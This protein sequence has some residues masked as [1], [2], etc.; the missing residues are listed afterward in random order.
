MAADTTILS[1]DVGVWWLSNNRAKMLTWEGTTGTYTMNELYSAMQTLQDESDTID[2]GTCFNAD[3]PT[4]YTIG[5]IDS[6]DNDPWYITYD[7]MEH[8]TGGSLRSSG[9]ARV[10][11]SNTGIVCV[12][13]DSGGTIVAGDAGYDITH[14]D[15]D[16]GTLLEFI[17]TGGAVDYCIIRPD[18]S[19]I[20]NSFDAASS[21]TLSCNGHSADVLETDGV[22]TTGDQIW[23]NIYS[24]GTVSSAVH[25]YVYQGAFDASTATTP[26]TDESNRVYSVNSASLDYWG[27]GHIDINVPLKDMTASTWSMI[28]DGYLRVFARKGGDL[29]S[30]FEVANSTTSGGRNPVPLQTSVDLNQGT[31]TKTISFS[32]SVSGTFI[33]GEIISQAT[34]N[35]R[36][37]LDLT[38]SDVGDNGYL[39]YFPIAEDTTGGALTAMDSGHLITGASSS[40]TCTTNGAPANAGPALSS[41]F[42]NNAF[43]DLQIGFTKVG[44]A[45][46]RD[47]DNDGTDEHY[48]IVVDCNDNTLAEVYE[49]LKYITQYTQGDTDMVEQAFTD[50]I[51][52]ANIFGE[53]YEGGTAYFGYSAISGTISEG[54]AV[55]QATSGAAGVIISHD[56]TNDVVLLRNTRGTF[57]DT[58][59]IDADYDSDYFTPDEAGNFAA[60]VSSPFGTFAGGT[61]FGARGI[62]LDNWLAADENAFILTDIEGNTAER[63][64]SITI[65]V[66]NLS[67]NAVTED[68]ADLVGVYLLSGSGGDID[69]DL[70]TCDGGEVEGG[71]SIATSAIPDWPPSSG[72]LLLSDVSENDEYIIGYSSYDTGTDTFTLDSTSAF[73][74]LTGSTD[75]NTLV[76][77]TDELD[78]LDRG[79][80]IWNETQNA[81]AYVK[82]VN[83]ATN[84]VELDRDI[85]GQTNG[86]TIKAN[87]VP[88]TLTA[89]DTVLPLIIH[90]FPTSTTIQAS[91]IYPGSTMYFRVKVRNSRET[92]LVNGPIKPYSSDGS[93][94]GTDQTIQTVRTIDTIIT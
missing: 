38:N 81:G 84:T 91:V 65:T 28:D 1:G 70:L 88:V 14:S 34:S 67:G 57:N 51:S 93:T 25:M 79:D 50:D 33:D 3:T 18:S 42:T 48:G 4:E 54:E 37:I 60:T 72:R 19:A 77:S 20:A 76:S 16:A 71:T 29:Y 66:S 64:T 89:S 80:F 52:Q 17:D 11:D 35:G 7:L 31:G 6:G 26:A 10:Q 24:I 53:E 15:G 23:A 58:N 36:G 92:D 87:V 30:S 27:Q 56:T 83:A 49:W 13:V 41:W 90:G 47:I 12:Q 8:I 59:Q 62:L 44:A 94:S 73:S 5:K 43:P 68:D 86:D 46:N 45:G 21:D 75:A 55:T 61:F 9:W 40:A 39:S 78:G 32:G 63:P 69:K 82:S 85:T 22:A 2:D 74:S